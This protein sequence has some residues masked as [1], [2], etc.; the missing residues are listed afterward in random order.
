MGRGL[1]RQTQSL[2]GACEES[3]GEGRGGWGCGLELTEGGALE[4]LAGEGPGP[5]VTGAWL[6]RRPGAERGLGRGQRGAHVRARS[7]R[8]EAA[9]DSRGGFSVV[10]ADLAGRSL[11]RLRAWATCGGRGP[12]TSWTLCRPETGP[13]E[14]GPPLLPGGRP[15]RCSVRA[16]GSGGPAR[17]VQLLWLALTFLR[18]HQAAARGKRGVRK[19]GTPLSAAR[20]QKFEAY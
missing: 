5:V 18:G 17:T 13:A 7:E 14:R 19:G 6:A 4:D 8:R 20:P 2:G 15:R 1:G 12:D 11:R 3:P 10:P 16:S 9:G